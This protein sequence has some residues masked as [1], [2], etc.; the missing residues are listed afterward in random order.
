M[1]KC[2]DCVCYEVCDRVIHHNTDVYENTCKLRTD[3]ET[4]CP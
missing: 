4:C 1:S 2:S 3:M